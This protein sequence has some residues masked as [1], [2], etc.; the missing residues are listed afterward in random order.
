MVLV[1]PWLNQSSPQINFWK[2]IHEHQRYLMF[3]GW[4]NKNLILTTSCK[5]I[6]PRFWIW[7][8]FDMHTTALIE[9]IRCL[10]SLLTNINVPS[11]LKVLMFF[12]YPHFQLISFKHVL[13]SQVTKFFAKF[14]L[15]SFSL[16]S[17]RY[18][19]TLSKIWVVNSLKSTQTWTQLII[20]T[21]NCSISMLL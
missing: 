8:T 6:N 3:D 1:S 13:S 19:N 14:T 15:F 10:N 18:S 4:E 11:E 20:G 21:D 7:D 5:I 2:D 17:C 16:L 9:K 12:Y